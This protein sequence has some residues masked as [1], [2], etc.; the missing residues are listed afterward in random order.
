MPATRRGRWVPVLLGATIVSAAGDP[1][2]ALP[3]YATPLILGVTYL[4]AAAMG[5]RGATLWAPGLVITVW[6]AAV[7]LVFSHTLDADFTAV[8]VTALGVGATGAALLGRIGFR[9]DA[10]AVAVSVLLAGITELAASAGVSLLAH[11]WFYGALL[12]VWVLGDLIRWSPLLR[13]GSA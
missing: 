7:V 6:G 9:V 5:G 2:A 12:G 1:V 13:R 3:S 8:A 11:G 4:G 10:L